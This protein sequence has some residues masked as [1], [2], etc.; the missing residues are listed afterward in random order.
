MGSRPRKS[1]SAT[2]ARSEKSVIKPAPRRDPDPAEVL[3]MLNGVRSIFACCARSLDDLAEPHEPY[4]P[5]LCGPKDVVVI[6]RLGIQ[7]LDEV[8]E[9]LDLGLPTDAP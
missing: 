3:D 2:S 8:H 1:S 6:V 4:A 5:E 7:K 9:A